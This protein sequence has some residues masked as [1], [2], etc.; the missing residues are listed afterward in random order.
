[1]VRRKRER[2]M[3]THK[4]TDDFSPGLDA[5]SLNKA[6]EG[7]YLIELCLLVSMFKKTIIHK[8]NNFHYS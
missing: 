3:G 1:M 7:Y 8:D 4:A 6:C 2:E 5:Q